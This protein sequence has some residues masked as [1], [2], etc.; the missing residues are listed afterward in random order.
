MRIIERIKEK[1]QNGGRDCKPIVIG[2]LGDSVTQ[3]CFE[4]YRTGENTFDTQFRSYAAYHHKLKRLLE[5]MYPG[6][7]FNIINA[8]ISGDNAP[9]GKARVR[10][11]IIAYKPDLVV[12]CFGLNDAGQGK[13]NVKQYTEALAG[14]FDELRA[15][16]IETI[17]MTPNMGAYKEVYDIEDPVIRNTVNRMLYIQRD[18]NLEYYLNA[19][20]SV[21]R[22]YGVPVCDCYKKWKTLEENGV[23][24][25]RLLSNRINH[26]SENMHWLF[27]VSL[28]EM[29]MGI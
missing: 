16:D 5:E 19:A 25:H 11:D 23:D 7:P 13:A 3:G 15:A 18:G 26:P 12:V 28:F 14:I 9:G 4:L 6:V 17:F 2:F 20:R 22:E 29:I 27:A 1:A 10:W 21:C 8:G 24:I